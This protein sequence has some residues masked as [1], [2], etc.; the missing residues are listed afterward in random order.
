MRNIET[1]L[2]VSLSEFNWEDLAACKGL[3]LPVEGQEF[4][5]AEDDWFFDAYEANTNIR[6]AADDI[7]MSCPVQRIC[8]GIGQKYR[9]EGLWG[10]IYLNAQGKPDP[11]RN[12][13]KTDETWKRLQRALNSDFSAMMEG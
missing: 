11:V 6:R 1:E 12:N 10:G 9:Q 4:V 5:P 2:G 8:H 7:C 3:G 13:H